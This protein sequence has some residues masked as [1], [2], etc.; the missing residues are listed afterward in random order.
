MTPVTSI[1]FNTGNNYL[2]A[3]VV[4]G[5]TSGG[6]T[7]DG[8]NLSPAPNFTPGYTSL[9]TVSLTGTQFITQI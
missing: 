3:L 2:Y 1:T 6:P 5:I 4:N 9:T 8:W 7:N